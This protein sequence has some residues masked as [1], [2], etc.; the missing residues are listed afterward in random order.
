MKSKI[1]QYLSAFLTLKGIKAGWTTENHAEFFAFVVLKETGNLDAAKAA[2][3]VASLLSMVNPSALRQAA[4][5]T[6]PPMLAKSED[7]VKAISTDW[8]NKIA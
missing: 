6:E 8:L 4:E 1:M 2:Q 7:K 3:E 5:K